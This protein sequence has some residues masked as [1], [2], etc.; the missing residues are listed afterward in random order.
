MRS[1]SMFLRPL[2]LTDLPTFVSWGEDRRFC[3]HAGWTVDL[4]ASAREAHWRRLIGQTGTGLVRLAAV[5]DDQVVGY[6][7]LAGEEPDRRELG[8]AIGPSA[9]WGQGF[10]AAAAR[11][12]LAYGFG[13]L[14]LR[15][16]EAEAVDAN[17]ASVRILRS[18]GMVETGRG[19]DEVFLGAPSYYRQFVLSAASW[20]ALKAD[21]I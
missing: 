12:G 6:V 3:E 9:R 21:R 18:I 4:A 14:G 2:E 19:H 20:Q 13:E 16:I 17:Q 1:G 11:L 15:E 5:A 7:D 8:Y 10:G